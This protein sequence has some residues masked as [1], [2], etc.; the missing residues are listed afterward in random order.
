[1]LVCNAWREE[2]EEGILFSFLLL[3]YFLKL[4]PKGWGC[5]VTIYNFKLSQDSFVT[6]KIPCVQI[7]SLYVHFYV[8]CKNNVRLIKVCIE[9][10]I[11]KYVI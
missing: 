9:Q 4:Y 1:V 3:P 6:G 2:E 11:I 7:Y 8:P 5:P 10:V